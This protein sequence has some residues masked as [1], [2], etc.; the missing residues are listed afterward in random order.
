MKQPFLTGL[1]VFF[2][3]VA[4]V[5][6]G[7]ATTGVAHAVTTTG[8]TISP[9]SKDIEIAPGG[10]YKGTMKVLNRSDT[11]TTFTVYAT[12]YSVTGEEYKP[13]FSPVKDAVDITKWFSFGNKGGPLAVG[14][15]TTIPYTISVPKG[16]GAGSYYATIFAETKDKAKSGSVVTHKR[17][18]M[19]VYLRVSGNVIEKGS[20]E[21]WK[22]P[23]LQKDSVSGT[24]KIANNGSVHFPATVS[25]N[26]R[27]VFG[28]KKYELAQKPHI[29]PQKL[30]RISLAWEK[31][32]SF[33]LY[34]VDGQVTY[35][36]KTEK[37]QTKYVFVAST[38]VRILIVCA[39]FLIVIALV[40]SGRKRV[41]RPKK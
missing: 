36:G 20:V 19:V 25:L 28:N 15:K 7:F 17:V 16:T 32:S 24:L 3:A 14:D 18:G 11:N 38:L 5:A 21:Q 23:F 31:S 35:L 33:G 29:L 37:L 40:I 10:S 30:R 26:V 1:K 8:L 39:I 27:D 12:P 4:I 34:K 6:G 22:V 2:V 13:Y 9:A 41:A